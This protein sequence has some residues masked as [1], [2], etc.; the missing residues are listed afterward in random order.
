L[1]H[2]LGKSGGISLQNIV[3]QDKGDVEKDDMVELDHY[4]R[5][6]RK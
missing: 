1:E 6:S 5:I 3:F 2:P 4:R